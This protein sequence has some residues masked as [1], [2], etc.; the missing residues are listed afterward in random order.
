MKILIIETTPATPH[1]ETALEL[2]IK[3][4]LAGSEVIY[5]PIFHLVPQL[6]W[7]SNIN[8]NNKGKKDSLTDWI[9]Y[10]VNIIN[11]FS[12]IDIPSTFDINNL[13]S[14]EEI[15]KD[16]LNF[17]YDGHP[18]GTLVSSTVIEIYKETNLELIDNN[19]LF[20]DTIMLLVVLARGKEEEKEEE[21]EEEG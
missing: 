14:L 17:S 16:P 6:F 15:K 1:A 3:E 19:K 18:L 2:G 5:S 7:K 10:L 20:F 4:A 11:K 21:E 8:G 12:L 13:Y 9:E